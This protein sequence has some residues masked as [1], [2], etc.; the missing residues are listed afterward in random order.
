MNREARELWLTMLAVLET[1]MSAISYDVWIKTLDVVDIVDG[2][3]VLKAQNEDCKNFVVTRF[4]PLIRDVM[5]KENPLLTEVVLIDPS[6]EDK[7]VTATE[8]V[9]EQI[10]RAHV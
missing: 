8:K 5:K 4:L 3:L 7:Y 9:D 10:G 6:E 2:K 1:E